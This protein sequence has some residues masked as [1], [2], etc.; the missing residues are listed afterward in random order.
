MGK[1]RV[2]QMNGVQ[3][4]LVFDGARLNMKKKVED[5]RRK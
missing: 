1:L 2:L 3:C 4:I 5:D